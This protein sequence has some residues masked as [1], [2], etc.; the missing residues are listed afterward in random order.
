MLRQFAPYIFPIVLVALMA[1]RMT[2]QANGRPLNPTRL[3]VRP[4]ILAV[5]LALA[6]LH[7]PVVT[8]ITLVAFVAAA[9]VGGVL[10]F[11]LASHQTLSV[12]VTTGKIMSKM[13]PVGTALFLALFVARYLMRMMVTGGQAPDEMVEHSDQ[14][15]AYTDAG[16]LFV[17]AL[18]SAQAWELWRRTRPL[19]AEQATR[20]A[21]IPAS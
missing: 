17:V 8:P 2:R 14:I 6:F 9:A 21:E 16:L 10:G 19:V 15:M 5:F 18:V 3:W 20:K 7:P 11:V 1:W 12:D 4:T 13:S